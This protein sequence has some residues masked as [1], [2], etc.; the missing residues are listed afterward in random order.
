MEIL[1]AVILSLVVSIAVCSVFY[2]YWKSESDKRERAET[3]KRRNAIKNAKRIQTE[4]ENYVDSA[5]DEFTTKNEDRLQAVAKV[6]YELKGGEMPAQNRI[7]HLSP[8]SREERYIKRN[9]L[10]EVTV[11]VRG[12]EK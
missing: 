8:Q 4:L 5:L 10:G 9:K 3:L 2:F 6:V 7:A 12:Q 1:I 11:S